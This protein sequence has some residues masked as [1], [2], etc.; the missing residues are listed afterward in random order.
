[1]AKASVA[2]ASGVNVLGAE[3]EASWLSI[4]SRTAVVMINENEE[5]KMTEKIAENIFS[6]T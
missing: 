1:M 4:Q 6:E 2:A 3:G 5:K